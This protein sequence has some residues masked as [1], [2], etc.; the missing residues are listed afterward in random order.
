MEDINSRL[1]KLINKTWEVI[2]KYPTEIHLGEEEYNKLIEYIKY[3][4]SKQP[5][6]YNNFTFA[7][8]KVIKVNV[9]NYLLA[10]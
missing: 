7:G 4:W 5:E 2:G 8:C 6:D 1:I 10:K 3:W 9:K